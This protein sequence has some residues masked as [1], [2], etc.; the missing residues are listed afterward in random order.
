MKI[1]RNFTG[2]GLSV[3]DL[4]TSLLSIF[5]QTKQVVICLLTVY[6]IFTGNAFANQRTAL[7]NNKSRMQA[8]ENQIVTLKRNLSLSQDKRNGLNKELL[9]LEKR[10]QEGN[11]RLQDLQIRMNQVEKNKTDL[12]VEI[13]ALQEQQTLHQI[14][15][16]QYVRTRY[17]MG[18]NQPLKWLLNQENPAAIGRYLT[19]Y[20][21]LIQSRQKILQQMQLVQQKMDENTKQLQQQLAEFQQLQTAWMA[22]QKKLEAD[23]LHRQMVVK[24]LGITIQT[25]EN[26]LKE[27]QRN[28][29]GLARLVKS[30]S[31]QKSVSLTKIQVGRSFLTMRNK[32]PYPVAIKTQSLRSMNQGVTFFADAG[33]MVHAVH[34]GKVVFSEWLKG[35]GLL[36]IVDH[37]QGFMTLYANNQALFKHKGQF[38]QQGEIIASVGHTGGLKENG[39]YFEVRHQGKAVPALAWFSSNNQVG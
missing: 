28:R 10:M 30:L 16:G 13:Q 2:C 4:T 14:H 8:L 21:Y 11:I 24:K 33:T 12:Q 19:Y 39:L 32:L 20:Q 6:F 26:S 35:Y 18:K 5:M 15:L 7:D 3:G 22:Q 27:A 31:M 25:T 9:S 17:K 23:R 36:V 34:P 1:N 38:V 37:G 29:E